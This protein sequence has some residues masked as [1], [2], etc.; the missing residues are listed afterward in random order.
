MLSQKRV[1]T[2]KLIAFVKLLSKENSKIGYVTEQKIETK[3]KDNSFKCLD[4]KETKITNDLP[5]KLRSYFDPFVKDFVRHGCTQTHIK[6][7]NI[8]I[9]YSILYA[10]LPKFLT[11]TEQ[12]Q[13]D[14][15]KCLRGKL[16]A[17]ISNTEVFKMNN[18]E[19]MKWDKKSIYTTLNNF[20]V[21]KL[22]L[23]LLADYFSINIFI[24]NI[25]EDKLY[26]VSGTDHYDMFRLNVFISLNNNTFE[27]LSYLNETMLPYNNMLVKKIISI[28]KNI[29]ILFNTNLNEADAQTQ[30]EFTFKL[31]DFNVVPLQK[32]NKENE[33]IDI[34]ESDTNAFVKDVELKSNDS[35]QPE[36]K[37]GIVFNISPKMKLDA[38]QE[39]ATKFNININKSG[40]NGKPKPKTKTELVD[41]IKTIMLK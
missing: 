10:C 26:V 35:S 16:I 25:L 21:T 1:E 23:K 7:E 3:Q 38:L 14:Y 19:N 29:L 36:D 12:Q 20:T 32:P 6:N 17:Y 8:S 15:I 13:I 22:T 33:Y 40:T 5:T 2:Q 37:V 18:Y 28:H 9:F 27:P 41:E 11:Y 4:Y 24:L 39:M 30:L 31:S 34:T